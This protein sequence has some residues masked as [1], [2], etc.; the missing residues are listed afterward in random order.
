MKIFKQATLMLLVLTALTGLVYPLVVTAIASL[1]SPRNARGDNDLIGKPFTEPRYFWGRPSATAKR[2]Y[3]ATTS[4]GS[5]LGPSSEA[6]TTAVAE[7]VAALHAAGDLGPPP[8]DLVTA[9]GSGLDPHISPEAASYQA[10]RIARLRGIPIARVKQLIQAATEGPT[11]GVL[12]A[13]RVHVAR[14][15]QSLDGAEP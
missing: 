2:P 8:V 5:N 7:R 4:S 1:V 10:P 3:D 9:S 14:L 13:P 11:L 6:L 15:N 12:G